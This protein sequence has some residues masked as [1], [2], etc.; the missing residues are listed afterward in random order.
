MRRDADSADE[1]PGGDSFLDIVANIVGILVLLVVVV[2]VR[3]GREVFVP[4]ADPVEEAVPI[5][6]LAKD[7]KETLSQAER[8][9]KQALDL[10]VSINAA[11]LQAE[12]RDV[13]REEAALYV[14]TLREELDAARESLNTDDRRSLDTHNAIAQAQLT[15]DRLTREQ[16]ALASVAP[17]PDLER[18]EVSPTPIVDGRADDA[19]YFRLKAGRLV[20]VPVNE[21]EAEV[22]KKI[23][24]P[25]FTDPSKR[26]VTRQTVGP[27]A[28]YVADVEVIWSIR[29]A[30]NRVGVLPRLGKLVLREVT[31]LRGETPEE[32]FAPG[33]YVGSR[34]ELL[35]PDDMVVQLI[36]YADSFDKAHLASE[37]L[38]ERGFRVAQS[39]KSN[40]QP[41]GFSADGYQAVTQ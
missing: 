25:P 3:A 20:Y 24:I 38:R 16:I 30:G 17:D 23:E 13:E 11:M 32:A 5:E 12:L 14:A 9:T 1:T 33:G 37:Q 21:I 28:G 19:T 2:G 18:V 34:L 39:L 15:L 41:I 35:N 36:V 6:A 40:G 4:Q 26:I 8:E 29:T 7:L 27:I 31:P 10:R 22:R